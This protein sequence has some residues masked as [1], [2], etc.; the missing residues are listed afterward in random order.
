MAKR[1]NRGHAS[2][3]PR[4]GRGQR[5]LPPHLSRLIEEAGASA[6]QWHDQSLA[7]HVDRSGFLHK[8]SR[9]LNY[10]HVALAVLVLAALLIFRAEALPV[11]A[12]GLVGV[13]WV[14]RRFRVP[15]W[16]VSAIAMIAALDPARTA[17]WA[18]TAAA[19]IAVVVWILIPPRHRDR[20]FLWSALAMTLTTGLSLEEPLR[21]ALVVL[22]VLVTFASAVWFSGVRTIPRPFARV[23]QEDLD[24]RPPS[25]PTSL[26]W[27]VRL[28]K[29]RE[30]EDEPSEIARKRIGADGERRTAIM[31]LALE[32]G[33]GTRI[34]HDVAIPGAD[35]A[36]ADHVVLARTGLFIIDSKQYGRRDDPGLVTYD[37]GS[38]EIVHRTN[39][40]S[41]SI[42]QSLRTAAWAVEG[43]SN[44]VGVPGRAILAIHNAA[45]AKGLTVVRNG[46]EIEVIPSWQLGERIDKSA[47]ALTWAQMA[48]GRMGM[49]RLKSST[50]GG[51]P[52]VTSPRGL[53]RSAREFVGERMT[54]ANGPEVTH[55]TQPKEKGGGGSSK[56]RAPSSRESRQSQAG[57]PR[58]TASRAARVRPEGPN[59]APTQNERPTS[60]TRPMTKTQEVSPPSSRKPKAATKSTQSDSSASE[61]VLSASERVSDRWEQMSHSEPA[62]PDD[63][64]QELRALS[65]GDGILIIEFTADDVRSQ[66]MTA[67][68]GVQSGV[69]GN[70]IWYCQP[71]QYQIH[72]RT[73]REVNVSTVSTAKVM[74]SP[75]GDAP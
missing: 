59:S 5:A 73:G 61:P 20:T 16:I 55:L 11:I 25:P 23:S 39:R 53:Q 50:T 71:E 14:V 31:L 66:K 52:F 22:T 33:K 65:R 64:E 36:N 46:V 62:P 7:E 12:G 45:V 69:D 44:V 1:R 68:S 35:S 10:A 47:P 3:R 28:M 74:V 58:A 67:M 13:G 54:Q 8:V 17:P 9:A 42:E 6:Y 21:S 57:S 49:F 18:I 2:A 56:K 40:G 72:Q 41:R 19:A 26:P 4:T 63:V 60:A 32:R 24:N 75:E 51:S 37:Q 43:V 34:A 29:A 70:Y 48:T 30:I 38:R 15:T 27:L